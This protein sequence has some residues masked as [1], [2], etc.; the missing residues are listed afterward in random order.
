M[1]RLK[2]I[3]QSKKFL[4]FSLFLII[5][6]V[7]VTTKFIK[8][9][10]VY[11]N[12]STIEGIILEYNIDGDKLSMII[13]AKEKVQTTYYFTSQEEKNKVID[14]LKLGIKVK[15]FGE[16]KDPSNNTMPNTFNY[17]KYLYNKKIYK[18]FK[19][20]KQEIINSN[21][22]LLYNIKNTF[23]KK[24]NS[25]KSINSYMQA[26]IW[27]D[28]DF[29][30]SDI[31]QTY[32]NNGVTHLFAVSGMHVSFLVQAISGLLKKIK[33][34]DIF[35]NIGIIIFLLFYMF[36]IGFSAS[37]VRASLLFI[38]MIIN[39]TLHLNIN[40]LIILYLLF[41]F[42]LLV[43]PFYIYDLGFLYSFLT[44][45]GLI[46]FSKKIKGNYIT[47][48]L[49]VSLVAT[50]F[51]LPVTLFN[52]YEFNLMTIFNNLIIVPIV[53][54]VLFPFTIITFIVPFLEPILE[55][56]FKVLEFISLNCNKLAIN[57]I[58]PKINIVFI[59][60]YYLLIYFIYRYGFKYILGIIFLI[61]IYKL[62]PFLDCKSSIYY[63]D[64]GQGDASIIVTEHVQ[65]VIM[66][67]TGG[68][69]AYSKELWQI[70][71]NNF[72]LTNNILS[73]LKSLGITKIDS[74]IITHGDYDHIGEATNIVNNFKIGKVIFNCGTY[75]NLEKNLI[76][77]LNDKRIE[78]SS[79]IN[80]LN[81]LDSKLLFLNTKEYNNENDNSSVVYANINNFKFLFMGD[82][83]KITEKEILNKY[84]LSNIDVLKVGHHG[85][86]TSSS[87][88]FINT[89]N[90]KYSLISVGKNNRYGHPNKEVLDNLD[91]SKI[92]RTDI[93]GSIMFKIKK[94][95]LEIET[96]TP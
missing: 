56:G 86:K 51:S 88:K 11:S 5:L 93:D 24:V 95:K 17:K 7:L 67:D 76:K 9:Q 71:N 63:L 31:Y 65:D 80:E 53:S 89:I 54:V 44:S 55:F 69:I 30:N 91:D 25:F 18:T 59:I 14:K 20:N 26:F 15:L 82:V 38:L 78:Y 19:I 74:L 2:I 73:F 96:Y 64:V 8:Y 3:L 70:R 13:N 6:Y 72:N 45:Y 68:I 49:F 87:Y 85:S 62:T 35:I 41:I 77:V 46:L 21:T 39:K 27:G 23:I 10:S 75:N 47:K 16:F 84:N 94:G 50:L 58:V 34:K 29:I 79:C 83:S 81:I 40:N 90:P 42:L 12:E 43:N 60:I 37:V 4:V 36:L 32:R 52:F 33:I 66:I 92:Y 57:I 1:K 22:S 28:K 61:S 48:L